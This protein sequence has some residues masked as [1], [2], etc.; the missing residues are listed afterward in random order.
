MSKACIFLLAIFTNVQIFAAK[1]APQNRTYNPLIHKVIEY[2][3]PEALSVSSNLNVE[4]KQKIGH[5]LGGA[6]S[7][8]S[9]GTILGYTYGDLQHR[10]TMGRM[11]GTGNNITGADTNVFV[12]FTWLSGPVFPVPGRRASYS[13]AGVGAGAISGEYAVTTAPTI[14]GY[15]NLNVT[16]DN[17]AVISGH[18]TEIG[19]TYDFAPTVWYD[20][21]AL[22][23]NF[24]YEATTVPDVI[25]QWENPYIGN[26]APTLWPH[27]AFQTTPSGSH[28]THLTGATAGPAQILYY[29]RK[30]GNTAN[31]AVGELS[32]CPSLGVSGWDCPWVYDTAW[33]TVA[34]VTAS[35]QSGKVALTWTANLPDYT[36]TPGCDTC[37]VNE[38]LGT[39][40]DRYENDVYY[41][42]SDNYGVT[43]NSMQ[44]VTHNDAS[45]ANWMPYNDIDALWDTDDELHLAWVATDWKRYREENILGYGARIY[46]WRENFGNSSSDIDAS[47][48]RVAVIQSQDPIMCN[49]GPYN[50]NLA[51]LQLSECNGNLY[52]LFVDLWD[53]HIDP[54]NPD[55]SKRSYDGDG[56]GAVNGELMVSISDNYGFSWDLPHN[57]TNSPSP[58]CDSIGGMIGPCDSD[59]YPSMP[60]HG[61]AITN[62][63]GAINGVTILPRPVSYPNVP[64]T[65]WLPIMYITDQDPGVSALNNG[66]ARDNP[67]KTFYMACV[68]PSQI[69]WEQEL[70]FG[71]GPDIGWPTF[72]Q[73]GE[74]LDVT[75]VLE[76]AGNKPLNYTLTIEELNGPAGWLTVSGFSGFVGTGINNSDTGT[77][78][79]NT[80]GIIN[81]QPPGVGIVYAGRIILAETVSFARC[82]VNVE[83]VVT[84]GEIL[85]PQK[86]TISTG[87]ILLA[88]N[89]IGQ[90]GL[91]GSGGESGG[92]MDY[93]NDPNECDKA[94]SIPGNTKIYLYDG[95]IIVGG[96]V[97]GD[98]ILS[99]QIFGPEP[100]Q[101]TSIYQLTPNTPPTTE[102][103]FQYWRSGTLTNHDTT[104]GMEISYYAPQITQN[105]GTIPGKTW[106]ADQHFITREFKVWSMDGLPHD[107]LVVGEVVDWDIPSDFGVRNSGDS[108]SVR[109]LLY[110]RG[111]DEYNQDDN[112]KCQENSSRYGGSAFGYFKKYNATTGKWTII[113]SVGYGGY[114]EPNSRISIGSWENNQLYANMANAVG[115]RPWRS[116]HPDSALTDLHTVMTYTLDNQL[117]PNDTLTFYSVL[118][119]VREDF[120]GPIQIQQLSERGRNFTYYF[121]C[122][123]GTK[124]DLN[125]DGADCNIV[126]LNFLV[127][128]VFRN[129][130]VPTCLGE[131][132]V[133]SDKSPGDILDL[134]FS[135]NRIFRGGMPPASCG[136]PPCN[137]PGCH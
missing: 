123:R 132:D 97:N 80:G 94:D 119:T 23:G 7:S 22:A 96:I 109:R 87:L 12:H 37:S 51:K 107:S 59:H 73:P 91:G 121:G 16:R 83:L 115:Y 100:M 76:N 8:S 48:S 25:W 19:E 5:S 67:V 93:W 40:R 66:I 95:S 6:S 86:D 117:Q 63:D 135:V 116:N 112:L 45:T 1:E 56:T 32:Y 4:F 120:F 3:L 125:G 65:E 84:K 89:T 10:N 58:H 90:F 30:E 114:Q 26:D 81:Q 130:Q 46:H 13:W 102:G 118:A 131:A 17:R 21:S 99:I 79:L 36:V 29:Y 43:W 88:L 64:G 126:D 38:S 136:M 50:Q 82:T 98:T 61:F 111:S 110:C 28:V 52:C 69:G 77:I 11:V 72:V 14:A 127:N 101:K 39:L 105:W 34:L 74:Q 15:F 92:R 54:A 20:S 49:A 24:I 55:C 108:S 124:G 104:L 137:T 68:G 134:N 42:T 53:G 75:R 18:Y 71:L 2:A 122:C 27:M 133:N 33:A 60:P 35:K 57:L 9:P 106:H 128:Y 41:Q 129:G 47:T 31:L 62:A 70:C 44:N 113:D 85:L 103:V 78:R